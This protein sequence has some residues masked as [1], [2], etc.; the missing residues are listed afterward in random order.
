M[1]AVASIAS[2]TRYR[3]SGKLQ[4]AMCKPL[5]DSRHLSTN[6]KSR[7]A[8][9]RRSSSSSRSM[10]LAWLTRPRTTGEPWSSRTTIT[11]GWCRF[12]RTLRRATTFCGTRSSRS[13]QQ[14]S[15]MVRKT[16]RSAS[17]WPSPAQGLPS[18]QASLAQNCTK[19]RTRESSLTCS[20][21]SLR[22]RYLG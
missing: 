3:L 2:R 17:A 11:A 19:I 16:T 4:W 7:P 15:S 5:P 8:P 13:T 12:P 9:T 14:A 1:D 18:Q 20:P 10:R 22:I 21:S 6:A